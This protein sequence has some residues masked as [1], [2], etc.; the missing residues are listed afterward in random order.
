METPFFSVILP[1]FNRLELLKIAIQSV[2]SQSFNSWELVIVNDASTDETKEYLD[3]LNCSKIKVFH[4]L[5]NL[6]KGGTRNIG[7][8]NST[9][10]YICF[11]DDDDYYIENHLQVF[12]EFILSCNQ[13]IAVFYTMPISHNKQTGEISKRIL[14]TIGNQ[15]P[16]EYYLDHK[17]GVPTPRMCIERTILN[18]NLFNPKIKIGQDT[19]L[20]LRIVVNYP[21]YPI[22]EHTSVMVIHDDN[23]GNLK[24]D[25]GQNRLEGLKII[26]SNPDIAKHIPI[27]LKNRMIAYCHLKS[28]EHYDFV[29][30]RILVIKHALKSLKASRKDGQVKTKLVFILYN[31]PLGTLIRKV[32]KLIK[33]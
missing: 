3:S 29:G 10:K 14:P 7:I 2:V 33:N 18:D 1:T 8:V 27:A 20:L 16:I 11:L 31:L 4:N 9:G 25:T 23:S 17:N 21:A 24:Y 13:K 19:E 30:N 12:Y 28:C 26:F 6:H 15:N 32:I 22:I 5:K